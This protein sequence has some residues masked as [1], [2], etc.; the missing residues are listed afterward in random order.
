[1][2]E[3]ISDLKIGDRVIR[4]NIDNTIFEITKLDNERITLKESDI[5]Y[6]TF[7]KDAFLRFQI[8]FTKLI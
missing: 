1:M 8:D 7:A 3:D 4:T 5:S 6:V 2:I